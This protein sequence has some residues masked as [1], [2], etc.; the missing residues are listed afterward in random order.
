MAKLNRSFSAI[1]SMFNRESRRRA[2]YTT[3]RGK[4]NP[5]NVRAEVFPG[6]RKAII[7][8]MEL[9]L[10]LSADAGTLIAA[11]AGGQLS[12]Y[13]EYSGAGLAATVSAVPLIDLGTSHSAQAQGLQHRDLVA[14][15]VVGE[16]DHVASPGSNAVQQIYL[17][18]DGATGLTYDGPIVVRGIDIPAFEAPS[19]LSGQEAEIADA[20]LSALETELGSMNVRVTLQRP[21]PASEYATIYVGGDGSPFA[22]YGT[23]YGLSEKIDSQNLDRVDEGFVFSAALP[24]RGQDASLFG[25]EIAGYVAHEIGHLLGLEHAHERTLSGPLDAVAFKPYTH[26]EVGVDVRRDLLDDGQVNIAGNDYAVDPRIVE[27]VRA[28]PS[29]YYGGVV[30]PGRLPRPS[31]GSVD[32]PSRLYGGLVRS[33][34]R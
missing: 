30:G 31:H 1:R 6:I 25:M 15:S 23:F 29:Y 11:D 17:D 19:H 20:L 3:S 28:Y 2:G 33:S 12:Q 9:R 24:V 4:A 22:E 34:A 13:Q 14:D 5:S 21:D 7:E 10:L 32:H 18:L 26:I 27:A 16:T 8:A